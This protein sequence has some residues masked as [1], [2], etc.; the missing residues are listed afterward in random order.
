VSTDSLCKEKRYGKV[1]EGGMKWIYI[2][3]M[4]ILFVAI[5]GMIERCERID[6][7]DDMKIIQGG[8]ER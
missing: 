5:W 6:N 7:G 3:L 8:V 1:K 2:I 4:F